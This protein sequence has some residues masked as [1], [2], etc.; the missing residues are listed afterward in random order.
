MSNFIALLAFLHA[1]AVPV[2]HVR[3]P[4]PDGTLDAAL[5]PPVSDAAGQTSQVGRGIAVVALH[6]CEGPLP[7]RD[8]SWAAALARDGF[9]VLLPDSFG[10]RGLGSQCRVQHRTVKPSGKRRQDAIAAA[11]WLQQQPGIAAIAPAAGVPPTRPS[12]AD[13]PSAAAAASGAA[14]DTITRPT[15]TALS[16]ATPPG[17]APAGTAPTAPMPTRTAPPDTAPARPAT[18]GTAPTGPAPTGMAPRGIALLGW[19]NGGGTVLATARVAPDLPPGL[20][21]RFVAFYPG[22]RLRARDPNW[23][24]AAPLMILVGAADDWTPAEP[25]QRLAARYP[26]MITLAVYPGAYHDFD[27]PDQPVRVLSGLTTP[28]SGTGRAHAGTDPAA[29]QDALQRVP[30]FLAGQ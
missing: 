30:A 2:T 26:G 7:R 5:V 21:Q 4:T 15:G 16:E 13:R 28:P 6:G 18:T 9:T 10:S 14:T 27:A 11:E 12:Q 23:K 24:P 8:G 3:I 19:S 29:R 1:A 20:F 22:C 25:C 17:T